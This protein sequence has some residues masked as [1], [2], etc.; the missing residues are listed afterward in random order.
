MNA[1]IIW[2]M[3]VPFNKPVYLSRSLKLIKKIVQADKQINIAG[4]GYYGKLCEAELKKIYKREILLTTSCTHA[5]EMAAIL[6]NTQPGDEIII[7]SYTFVSTALAFE[8]RGAKIRFIDIDSGTGNI[9]LDYINNAI[10]KNTKAI[11]TVHYAGNSMEM[12][13][14]VRLCDKKKIFLIEDAAQAL[15][16][17]YNGKLLGTFGDLGTLSFHET[18]NITSGEGGA[19]II[20]NKKLLHRAKIIREK[21]TN[22]AQFKEGLVDKYSWVDIGSSYILSDL[23][24]AYLYPQIAIYKKINNKRL[25]IIKQYKEGIKLKEPV[26]FIQTPK[27]NKSNG[28]LCAI[29]CKDNKQRQAFISFMKKHNVTTPFHYVSLHSSPYIINKYHRQEKLPNTDRLSN[30]LVRLP[31]YYDLKQEQVNQVI[32]ITNRFFKQT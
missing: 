21:G 24:A 18:K 20:N 19:L 23:N 27:Y 2:A 10:N 6:I 3:K 30:C 4:D 26:Y 12:D 17:K 29:V 1:A 9:T 22:R 31:L 16:S 7:P 15:G 11:V 13:K 5:L 28:H 14:L 25:N 8:D 32:N